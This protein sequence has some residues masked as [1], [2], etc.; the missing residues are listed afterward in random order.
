MP[1][2]V[3]VVVGGAGVVVVVGGPVRDGGVLPAGAVVDPPATVT[4]NFMP[5]LQW[6]TTPQIK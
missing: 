2:G 5:P 1:E 3:V 6:P 4:A